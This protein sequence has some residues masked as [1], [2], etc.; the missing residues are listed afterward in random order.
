VQQIRLETCFKWVKAFSRQAEEIEGRNT[1]NPYRYDSLW[2]AMEPKIITNVSDALKGIF[3][4]LK[5][6]GLVT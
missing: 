4:I 6:T 3:N 2:Q 1:K 5:N